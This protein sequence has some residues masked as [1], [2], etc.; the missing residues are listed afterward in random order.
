MSFD[1]GKFQSAP[2]VPREARVTVTA[3]APF[4]GDADPV[5]TVR[6]LTGY[7][8]A[9]CQ[10]AVQMNRSLATL[11]A[12]LVCDSAKEKVD[13]IR[14]ALG[15]SDAV[16]DEIAK[17]LEMLV[18]AAVDPTFDREA[19]VRLC[20]HFPVE[21]YSITTEIIRLTGEGASLGESTGCGESPTSATP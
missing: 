4:F 7:E 18:I 19:A 16:P 12:G 6:Q 5:V 14:R 2:F 1:F 8:L 11:V 13:S 9:R 15:V 21:F 17:R 3:L 20:T 10:E